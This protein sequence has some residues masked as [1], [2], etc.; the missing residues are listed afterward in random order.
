MDFYLNIFI[1]GERRSYRISNVKSSHR[2]I[3]NQL[4]QRRRSSFWRWMVVASWCSRPWSA[5]W[6]F[7]WCMGHCE[8]CSDWQTL[9]HIRLKIRYNMM[10]C[11]QRVLKSWDETKF[12]LSGIRPEVKS[13]EKINDL[14]SPITD[15]NLDV[16]GRGNIWKQVDLLS[17]RGRA[18]LRVCQ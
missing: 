15:A 3:A 13:S 1:H 11:V 5:D 17:Q 8:R 7:R 6:S 9:I 2:F 18:M 16:K 12:K 14:I 10:R 4:L